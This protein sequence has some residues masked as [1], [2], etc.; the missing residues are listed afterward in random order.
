MIDPSETEMDV[1][2]DRLQEL[3]DADVIWTERSAAA[4]LLFDVHRS[5]TFE[6]L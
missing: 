3:S 6:R 1:L 2:F 4:L 5:T